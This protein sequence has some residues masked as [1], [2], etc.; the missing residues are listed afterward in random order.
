MDKKSN[1]KNLWKYNMDIV[2]FFIECRMFEISCCDA[3]E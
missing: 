3:M 1:M 2:L